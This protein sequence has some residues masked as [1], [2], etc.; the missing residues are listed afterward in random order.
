LAVINRGLILAGL[1]FA[2]QTGGKK[3]HLGLFDDEDEAARKYDQAAALL[4]WPLNFPVETSDPCA[5]K[6]E[7]G[8]AFSRFKGVSKNGPSVGRWAA[9]IQA[10]GKKTHL[11]YFDDEAEAARKY[12]EAA[13]PLGRPLNF[14][15]AA[16][17]DPGGGGEGGGGSNSGAA[18]AHGAIKGGRGGTSRFA[19][20]SLHKGTGRWEAGIKVHGV[21]TALGFFDHEEDAARKYDEAAAPLGRPLNFPSAGGLLPPAVPLR[22]PTSSQF[23]GVTWSKNH[24]K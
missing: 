9:Q 4:G 7:K 12:D 15:P 17:T 22:P 3:T 5:S 24:K 13:A 23:K 19:G 11:G 8:S 2:F 18:A 1:G 10:G 16:A 21:K 20:V 6:E 14:P